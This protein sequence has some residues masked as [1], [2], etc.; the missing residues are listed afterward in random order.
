MRARFL[1]PAFGIILGLAHP[2]YLMSQV[3]SDSAIVTPLLEDLRALLIPSSEVYSE[4]LV[5]E[6]AE[7]HSV[8]GHRDAA[9][10]ILRDHTPDFNSYVRVALID[11]RRGDIDAAVEVARSNQ[12]SLLAEDAVRSVIGALPIPDQLEKALSL[13][14]GIPWTKQ[15]VEALKTLAFRVSDTDRPRA[16]AILDEAQ[17]VVRS[18]TSM[19]GRHFRIDLIYEQVRYGNYSTIDTLLQDSIPR[20]SRLGYLGW[21]A[22]IILAEGDSVKLREIRDRAYT[23]LTEIP[24]DEE[25]EGLQE[26]FELTASRPLSRI[27]LPDHGFRIAADPPLIVEIRSMLQPGQS[28]FLDPEVLRLLDQLDEDG[29][30]ENTVRATALALPFVWAQP[31]VFGMAELGT[32]FQFERL[33]SLS[34]ERA[35][36]IETSEG[37]DAALQ[38]ISY[39]LLRIDFDRSLEIVLRT[40][41]S[42]GRDAALRS[43]IGW[44]KEQSPDLAMALLAELHNPT[45][46]AFWEEEITL[47]KLVLGMIE[48]SDLPQLVPSSTDRNTLTERYAAHL[49]DSGQRHEEALQILSVALG[50]RRDLQHWALEQTGSDRS[51]ILLIKHEGIES[52]LTWAHGYETPERAWALVRVARAVEASMVYRFRPPPYTYD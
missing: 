45:A 30:P 12:D 20:A 43:H 29:S 4:S 42:D 10:Q 34:L 27:P 23:L 52:A 18:D 32:R 21:I 9:I 25:R 2:A 49:L 16:W 26:N 5:T 7:L 46:E 15:R 36:E 13:T 22:S 51:L 47:R 19:W 3:P 40:D 33:L 44:L 11:L 24:L 48:L 41:R 37:R 14:R 38:R 1:V 31:W 35:A 8:F 39:A 50:N 17:A 6:V 28:G